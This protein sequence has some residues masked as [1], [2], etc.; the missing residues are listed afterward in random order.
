MCAQKLTQ[1]SSKCRSNYSQRASRGI[2]RDGRGYVAPRGGERLDESLRERLVARP[3]RE[4]GGAALRVDLEPDQAEDGRVRI[5][6]L[7]WRSAD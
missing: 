2:S 3:R 7:V 5:G 4:P 6:H 1:A